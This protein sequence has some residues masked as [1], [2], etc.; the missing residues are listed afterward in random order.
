MR[1]ASCA[2]LS[3]HINQFTLYF[4]ASLKQDLHTPIPRRCCLICWRVPACALVCTQRQDTTR[5]EFCS[6]GWC[7]LELSRLH[8]RSRPSTPLRH[9]SHNECRKTDPADCEV[10]RARAEVAARLR[11]P[12]AGSG[13]GQV[14]QGGDH[15]HGLVIVPYRSSHCNPYV[16]R[17]Q[18]L[19]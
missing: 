3:C 13:R 15:C 10:R 1:S 14:H 11:Q 9:C 7:E 12:P 6:A 17:F 19:P 5:G 2:L 18:L 4:V 8:V 16:F